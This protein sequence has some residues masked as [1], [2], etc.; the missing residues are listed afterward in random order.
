MEGAKPHILN[1]EKGSI[2]MLSPMMKL[3][4]FKLAKK[5]EIHIEHFQPGY[6]QIYIGRWNEYERQFKQMIAKINEY[7]EVK[8]VIINE[9]A[10]TVAVHY[11]EAMFSNPAHIKYWFD[12]L[13]NELLI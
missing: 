9:Q 3:K 12:I 8:S 5:Y 7:P 13:E 1:M 10:F 6:V 4:L 2:T 11:D